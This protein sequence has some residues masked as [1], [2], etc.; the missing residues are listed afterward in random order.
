MTNKKI[1]ELTA[2]TSASGTD[3]L[4]LVTDNATTP[5]TKKITLGTLLGDLPATGLVIGDDCN[6]YR[7]AAN[8]LNTDDNLTVTTFII[9]SGAAGTDRG[10]KLQ[11]SGSTRWWLN[12]TSEAE[13]GANAGTDFRILKFADNGSYNG[14]VLVIS[15][16][17]GNI[18]I[19]SGS[20]VSTSYLLEVSGNVSASSIYVGGNSTGVASTLG[21]TNVFN[22]SISSGVG[23][24]K[25]GGSTART[26]TGFLK[27]N[28]GT[29]IRYIPYF[30]DITG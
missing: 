18:L 1:T 4:V 24:I 7:R 22:E 13:A 17:T 3:L 20:V 8:A 19:G 28:N 21:L 6:L 29:S 27:I 23:S 26:N 10:V 11:S 14:G 5:A 2:A 16:A 30:T 12:E 25:M 15:R 9:V